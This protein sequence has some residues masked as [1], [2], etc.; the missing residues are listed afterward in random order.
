MIA[1]GIHTDKAAAAF[2]L[3]SAGRKGVRRFRLAPPRS[4]DHCGDRFQP[5]Q[6]DV[7]AGG[8]RFCSPLCAR[9]GTGLK[10]R[11]TPEAQA[12]AFWAQV[13]RGDSCWEW[14]GPVE[15]NGYGL[16]KFERRPE[17][18]HRVAFRLASGP[19]PAGQFVCHRC[20]NRRCCRPDHLF[21][22]TAAE[23]NADMCLKERQARGETSG[24]AK[25]TE[26]QV[27]AIRA[28]QRQQECIAAAYGVSRSLVC[29]I[30]QR[31]LW[32]HVP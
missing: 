14:Q 24:A 4:C 2:R 15:P 22:G 9:K 27:K 5:R 21:L 25:L 20:D 16:S 19:V 8:G 17:R 26:V 7:V 3:C 23:N 18:A 1:H 30:R 28:D 11:A 31:K 13:A 10:A 29:M 12:E 32:R 6:Q